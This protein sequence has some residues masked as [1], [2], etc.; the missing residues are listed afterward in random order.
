MAGS[1]WTLIMEPDALRSLIEPVRVARWSPGNM[2]SLVAH[3]RTAGPSGRLGSEV[4]QLSPRKTQFRHLGVW[5]SQRTL[6]LR[7]WL[8]ARDRRMRLG[9]GPGCDWSFMASTLDDDSGVFIASGA[10]VPRK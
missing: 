9:A 7:H 8:Q 3:L 6:R 5:A 10:I 1:N 4:S 2:G